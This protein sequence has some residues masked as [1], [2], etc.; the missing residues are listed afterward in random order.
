M[1]DVLHTLLRI[2]AGAALAAAVFGADSTTVTAAAALL[3]GTLAATS[4]FAKATT[5]AAANTSPEPF[6]NLASLAGDAAVPV[7]LWLAFT[8]PWPFFAALA[9]VLGLT[10]CCCEARALPGAGAGRI[11]GGAAGEARPPPSGGHW[12]PGFSP[13]IHRPRSVDAGRREA[14][15]ESRAYD[16]TVTLQGQ[17]EEL[18]RSACS[19]E[20]LVPYAANDGQHGRADARSL[21]VS[22]SSAPVGHA[23]ARR[24]G[25]S[26]L[27]SSC[28]MTPPMVARSWRSSPRRAPDPLRMGMNGIERRNRTGVRSKPAA[29]VRWTKICVDCWC[30]RRMRCPAMSSE[31]MSLLS[32]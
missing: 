4:H 21:A 27:R 13:A 23:R 32:V 3:G 1:W 30:R 12:R 19:T 6:S 2:P 9:V 25:P 17:I 8:H 7:M 11:G 5:R 24:G 16:R 18:T 15:S 20:N 10:G 26:S 14:V 22:D 28:S 29:W 31:S